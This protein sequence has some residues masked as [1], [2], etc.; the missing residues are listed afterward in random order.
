MVKSLNP[1]SVVVDT[2]AM[3]TEDAQEHQI[4]VV[5]ADNP[6]PSATPVVALPTTLLT[7]GLV[8]ETRTTTCSGVLQPARSFRLS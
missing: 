1:T 7:S 2:P 6:R 8:T 4:V 5:G 3:Q